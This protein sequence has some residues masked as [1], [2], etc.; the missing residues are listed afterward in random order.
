MLNRQLKILFLTNLPSPYR[1]QF[2][3]ELGRKCDLTVL[4]QRNSSSERN[5]KWIAKSENT[6]KIIFLKGK[7]TGVDNAFCPRVIRYL[8]KSYDA[9][10]ICGNA[11]PTEILAIE[12]CR[13]RKIPYCLEG[14]GA[15]INL[16]NG[17]KEKLKRHLISGGSLFFSTCKEHDKYY[18]HYG[19]ESS[20]V[21]RYRF[22]SL[23][24]NDILSKPLSIEE[25]I[26]IR[27]ELGIK[28]DKMVLA[29]GQFIYRKGFD[30][31]LKATQLLDRDIAVY[32]VGDNPTKEYLDFR[33]EKS[34]K[35]V[36]FEGF[37]TKEELK[38]YYKA[39]D[40]FVLPTREDIWGLVVNEAMACGLP[41]ITTDKCNAGL[42]LIENNINGFVVGVDDPY[43]L[44]AKISCAVLNSKYMG[45]NSLLKI[46][47]YCIES[48]ASD[49]I[50]ILQENIYE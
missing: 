26:C 14:D 22:S 33:T 30:V 50:R 13:L 23:L 43:T 21:V 29:V 39:A 9:I 36:H 18:I 3:N 12:W 10:I 15:F 35:N 25:K 48:M 34:L 19:A 8:N 24:S 28:E 49:H 11:S 41:V 7:N 45:K 17:F 37:K 44:A 46:N 2:F 42:E 16:G 31:L 5:S 6:Y 4:Y 40:V 20:R 1:V 27:N 32:I 38:R 47:D